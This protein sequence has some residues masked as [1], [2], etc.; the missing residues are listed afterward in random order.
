MPEAHDAHHNVLEA[1][2]QDFSTQDNIANEPA[3]G[4]EYY[5]PAQ[6]PP[7]GVASDPQPDGSHPPKLFQPL[8]L[9]GLTLHNRIMVCVTSTCPELHVSLKSVVD[10]IVALAF[11]PVLG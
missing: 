9:R 1:S 8:K 5:T 6:N 4:A 2:K 7:A 3:K 11:V 10:S